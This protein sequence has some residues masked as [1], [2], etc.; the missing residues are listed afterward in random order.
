MDSGHMCDCKDVKSWIGPTPAV[1]PDLVV[2]DYYDGPITTLAKCPN[3]SQ[4]LL[5][6]VVAWEP[7]ISPLRVFGV[8]KIANDIYERIRHAIAI[9]SHA[10]ES[11][12]GTDELEEATSEALDAT[13]TAFALLA[14]KEL[15]R[16]ILSAT[17]V[18]EPLIIREPHQC[19]G[20]ENLSKMLLQLAQPD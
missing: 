7:S 4:P 1:F 3:C 8:A 18:R 10:K 13:P 14:T 5:I 2:V 15:D 9:R 11:E 6:S 20:A 16:R 17:L 12:E 19:V